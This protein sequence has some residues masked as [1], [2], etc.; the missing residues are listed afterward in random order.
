MI[1]LKMISFFNLDISGTN[2]KT[3]TT[4]MSTSFKRVNSVVVEI[5]IP[6]SSMDEKA[7][8]GFRNIFIYT[9]LYK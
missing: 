3:T 8:F 7:P 5:L 2:G 1:Y 4:Q 6:L 9:S